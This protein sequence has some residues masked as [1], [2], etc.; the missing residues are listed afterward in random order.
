MSADPRE[1]IALFRYAVVSA[2]TN[3]RLTP[4]ERGQLVRELASQ[5][6]AHPDGSQWTYSR[7]TLD[8]WIRGYRERGL[9]GLRPPPRADLG[10]VRRH[11][12]LLEEA[13]QLRLEL[14]ARSAAQIAA[15]LK[16]RHGIYLPERT[17]RQQLRRRGLHRAALTGQPRA[18][19]RYEAE[20]PNE[21]WIG[22]V[23]MGPFVPCPRVAGSR[24]AKLFLLV[25]DHSRLL[26]H[27]CWMTEENTRAGQ[28][29][30]R[31][32]ICRRGMPESLYLDNG[33]P[34]A[35]HMLERT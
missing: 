2:A 30:L 28:D 24:K 26:V 1:A 32:A 18:F 22:D 3:P 5:A 19:G 15:I 20:R 12:E 4:A 21:R 8:R 7:G 27:G 23:L 6:H 33:A 35:N 11:P 31:A 10:T 9:D 13:C 25:D 14:P 29:V 17:I 16:A 34:F